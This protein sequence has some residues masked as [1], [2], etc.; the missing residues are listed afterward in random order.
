MNSDKEIIV[1]SSSLYSSQC[2]VSE[3]WKYS[4]HN[5]LVINTILLQSHPGFS[6]ARTTL[7]E[8][9]IK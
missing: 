5:T 1:Q 6:P 9:T 7:D 8:T 3:E 2:V 4:L